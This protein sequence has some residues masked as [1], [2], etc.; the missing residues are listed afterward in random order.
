MRPR[1]LYEAD[2]SLPP[3][4][5]LERIRAACA[6][7]TGPCVGHVGRKHLNLHI[8]D[9]ERHLWSPFI[10]IE[11]TPT[12]DGAHLRGYFGPHPS[13]WGIYTAAYAVQVFVFIAGLMYG[14]ISWTLDLSLTGLWV[15]GAMVVTL[16]LSC[17]TNIAGEWAGA[18]QMSLTRRFVADTLGP[19]V[20]GTIQVASAGP[21]VHR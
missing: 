21:E 7:G 13:L 6:A 20:L 15:A 9:S 19:D 3:D 8:H 10:S 12:H 5:V 17:A 2:S 18:P 14:W 4:Q 16:A 11:V 1:P